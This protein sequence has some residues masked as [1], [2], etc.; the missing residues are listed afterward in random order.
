M[1]KQELQVADDGG[2]GSGINFVSM[3]GGGRYVDVEEALTWKWN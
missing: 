3:A 1:G 2:H